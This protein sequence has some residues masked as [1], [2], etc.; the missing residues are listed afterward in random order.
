[1]RKPKPNP[2]LEPVV[3]AKERANLALRL[4]S[5]RE[6]DAFEGLTTD[7]T[8]LVDGGGK[9]WFLPILDHRTRTG[10]SKP[11]MRFWPDGSGPITSTGCIQACGTKRPKERL[12]KP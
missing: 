4:L 6:P 8:Q 12:Q 1:M 10:T 3:L 7:F 2:L 9:V 11:S 5:E